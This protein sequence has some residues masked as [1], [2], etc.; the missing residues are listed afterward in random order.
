VNTRIGGVAV[1]VLVAL[2]ALPSVA[3][4]AIHVDSLKVTP[5]TTAA[6]AHPDVTV[7]EA[8]S[9][10]DTSDSILNSTLHFPAGLLGN[11][12]ASAKCSV[13]ERAFPSSRHETRSSAW[14]PVSVRASLLDCCIYRPMRDH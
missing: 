9:Y 4:G 10:S 11:P 7:N 1:V 13:A 14:W 8:F 12:Q 5:S 2:C 3:L 6:G